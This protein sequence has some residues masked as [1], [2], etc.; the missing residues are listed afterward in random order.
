VAGLV[1]LVAVGAGAVIQGIPAEAPVHPGD[2]H[3]GGPASLASSGTSD[4]G[5][6][7][8]GGGFIPDGAAADDGVTPDGLAPDDADARDEMRPDNA[9]APPEPTAT[10]TTDPT[11]VGADTDGPVV[12][13]GTGVPL[14]AAGWAAPWWQ[15]ALPVAGRVVPIEGVVRGHVRLDVVGAEAVQITLTDI[16]VTDPV[17]IASVRVELSSGDV[18]GDER[19]QWVGDD[20]PVDVGSFTPDGEHPVLTVVDP[21]VLPPVVHAV[22]L[23]DDRTGRLLGGAELLPVP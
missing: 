4:D 11:T 22:L 14:D 7:T 19:A 1:L 10:R 12:D 17:R 16:R 18:L 15:R 21:Q 9:L 3:D 13:A 2:G 20:H 6:T 5:I 8:I 23:V